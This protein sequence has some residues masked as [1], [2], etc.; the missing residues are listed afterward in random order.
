M[1]EIRQFT[2]DDL[3]QLLEFSSEFS[4]YCLLSSNG[5]DQ[6]H[7]DQLLAFGCVEEFT[8]ED[9]QRCG[10]QF[11]NNWW[12]GVCG[13]D[14]KKDLE[15]AVSEHQLDNK[16]PPVAFFRPVGVVVRKGNNCTLH[17]ENEWLHL[18]KEIESEL[19]KPAPKV[20]NIEALPIKPTISKAAYID[21]VQRLKREIRKGAI[22]EINYCQEFKIEGAINPLATYQKLTQISPMP[23]AGL[24]KFRDQY[25]ISSSPERFFDW[26]GELLRS[27]PI[28][29]SIKRSK[30]RHEDRKNK[31]Y[32]LLS[33][34]ERSEN[35]MI[36]D[37]VR[38][39]IGKIAK[40]GTVHVEDLFQIKSFKRIHQ[41]VSTVSGQTLPNT[42]MHQVFEALFPMGSMTG[43]PKVKAMEL[44][45]ALESGP[46]GWYSGCLGYVT[47]KGQ[48]DFNVLIRTLNYD[49][50]SKSSAY[51]VGGAITHLSDPE[52]EYEECLLKALPL[53]R[54]FDQEQ[55]PTTAANSTQQAA[56]R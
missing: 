35:V 47:P 43:A 37:L 2:A 1:R 7:F 25:S 48:M 27:Q 42:S 50:Q 49:A 29:G 6:E 11:S 16:F 39:D 4:H 19:A 38:N 30:D 34:K 52:K 13:Y 55:H 44:S 56:N 23:F 33:Q 53:Y 20:G 14:L 18:E 26:D 36:V 31:E 17:L 12:F 5:I 28:K 24:F 32:L 3:T 15:P 54:L 46:R 10:L 8:Y 51:W 22:Y 9:F 45:E 40:P 21:A 41:M